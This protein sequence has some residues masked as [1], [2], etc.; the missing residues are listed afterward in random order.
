MEKPKIVLVENVHPVAKQK[1]EE[2]RFDVELK[3][4]APSEDELCEIVR[5]CHALGLRSRSEITPKVLQANVNLL[6][7]GAF[8]IGPDQISLDCANQL[9]IPAFNAPCSN[10]RSVAELVIP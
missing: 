5:N 2:Q 4:Y 1:L 8:R 10:T 6:A 7:I 3:S 9:G